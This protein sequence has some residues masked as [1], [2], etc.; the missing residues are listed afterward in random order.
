MTPESCAFCQ[1]AVD[2]LK[3]TLEFSSEADQQAVLE[4]TILAY[5]KL[6]G[7]GEDRLVCLPLIKI[8]SGLDEQP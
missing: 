4:E 6:F 3:K 1:Q 5:G 8:A 2:E 7:C